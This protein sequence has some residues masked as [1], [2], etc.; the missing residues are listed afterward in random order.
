MSHTLE[1][2]IQSLTGMICNAITA[3]KKFHI[4][5]EKLAMTI[6]KN[7]G[8]L[9]SRLTLREQEMFIE[10]VD[11]TSGG[12]EQIRIDDVKGIAERFGVNVTGCASLGTPKG[13]LREDVQKYAKMRKITI[14]AA[15]SEVNRTRINNIRQDAYEAQSD[16]INNEERA[17]TNLVRKVVIEVFDN[18]A[19]SL[20]SQPSIEEVTEDIIDRLIASG[21]STVPQARVVV[22]KV[23]QIAL[24]REALSD[25]TLVTLNETKVKTILYRIKLINNKL[26][27]NLKDLN[28]I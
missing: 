14:E 13:T 9:F 26:I 22:Q 19:A 16:E 27:K 25:I 15:I 3:A 1:L 17:V 2:D 10:L 28:N 12:H 7:E 24:Y 11:I 4:Q 20:F 8:T 18:H 21:V 23:R 6:E 5:M